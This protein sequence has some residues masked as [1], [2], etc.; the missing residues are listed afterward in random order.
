MKKAIVLILSILLVLSL[1]ACSGDT[2]PTSGLGAMLPK[3]SSG[4]V[5]IMFNDDNF[6][7]TVDKAK[8]DEFEKYVSACVEMGYTV[9]VEKDGATYNAFNEDGYHLDLS[10]FAHNNS[11]WIKLDPPIE[12]GALRWPNGAIGKM[13][14]Q[15]DSKTGKTNSEKE[16]SFSLYV[17][18]T[19][20][21]QFNTYADKCAEA[22]FD[23]EYD[24]GDKHYSADNKDGYHLSLKFEGFNIMSIEISKNDSADSKANDAKDT[25]NDSGSKSSS[26]SSK[27][28][29][30]AEDK[31]ASSAD[32]KKTADSGEI[33][34]DIKEAIDS[35]EAFVD[36]YCEFMA[37][38]D[39][40]DVT[41]LA[42]YTSLVTKELEMTN[43]FKAI[44]DQDLN[45]AEESYYI[46]VQLRCDQKL[47]DVAG[48]MN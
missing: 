18:D 3:P 23:V 25:E 16:N 45:D 10:A 21:D 40:S 26:T 1:A 6:Y 20:L 34:S 24:R 43:K 12:M 2:W 19:T 22:G 37:S 35:Y 17:G 36:E 7:A 32:D 28:A 4:T 15:P 5:K 33:R 14:P 47:I 29:S 46:E 27:A 31:P 13:I 48:K 41:Q 38:Y 8:P 11:M 9:D 39:S 44:E 42:K 30:S